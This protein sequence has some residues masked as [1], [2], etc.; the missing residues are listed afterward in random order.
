M[1]SKGELSFSSA[2]WEGR[3]LLALPAALLVGNFKP[4]AITLKSSTRRF[5]TERLSLRSSH[6]CRLNPS[7][8]PSVLLP[9]NR[10]LAARAFLSAV[11]LT[12]GFVC[13]LGFAPELPNP[14]FTHNYPICFVAITVAT[15]QAI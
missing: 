9:T 7:P 13:L 10:V 14:R 8:R 6:K 12:F 11:F 4:I 15:R 2:V 5:G 1:F 3:V